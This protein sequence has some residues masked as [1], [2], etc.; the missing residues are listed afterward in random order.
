MTTPTGEPGAVADWGGRANLALFFGHGLGC[1]ACRGL[2]QWLAA[3]GSELHGLDAEALALLPSPAA[4]P[5]DNLA[6]VRLAADP[7]GALRRR[8]AD[9]IEFDAVTEVMLF[10]LDRFGVPYA[11]WTGSEADAPDLC[12]ETLKWLEYIAIQCPE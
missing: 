1:P 6:G 10:V 2:I 12:R 11:A 5:H 9:L 4:A 7:A 3:Q 8:Y